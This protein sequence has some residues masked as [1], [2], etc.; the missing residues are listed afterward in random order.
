[1]SRRARNRTAETPETTPGFDVHL[2][3]FEGPFDLLLQLISRREL[4]VTQVALS[5]VTD[6]FVAYVRAWWSQPPSWT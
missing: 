1:M 3:N 5:Q 2:A 4:D 6:E